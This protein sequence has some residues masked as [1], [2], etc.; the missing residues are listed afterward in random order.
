MT[1]PF[2]E[3]TS[4]CIDEYG[5]FLLFAVSNDR[6]RSDFSDVQD[7]DVRIDGKVRHVVGIE[8][9]CHFPPYRKGESIILKVR[10]VAA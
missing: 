10:R 1:I 3:F 8:R 5:E 2:P 6:D 9:F 4:L 7:K